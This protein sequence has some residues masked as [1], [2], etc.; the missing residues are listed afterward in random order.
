MID[1]LLTFFVVFL[2]VVE[3]V[4]VI[5]IFVALTQGASES[6]RRRMAR[7][8]VFIAAL[9]LFVFALVGGPF[10]NMMGISI[11]SFRIFGGVLLFLI[12]LEMVFARSSGSRTSAPEEEEGRQ[13]S[14]ISVFPLA[15]P[16]IAGPGALATI[17]LSFGSAGDDPVLFLG[18]LACVAVVLVIALL[19]LYLASPI[20]RLMGVTGANVLNRLFGVVLGALAVQF[21]ID[22]LRGSFPSIGH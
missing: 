17:L 1:Q 2:V 14:D 19:T 11:D 9:I 3:P 16:F 15:F 20:M 5:P 18:L 10:L 7:K 4:G 12:A 8:G 6:E 13:R 22:G 21:V